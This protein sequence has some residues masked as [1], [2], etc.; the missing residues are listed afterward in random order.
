[1]KLLSF[2]HRWAG[3][4]IGLLLAVLGLSGTILVWEG[5][6]ISLPGAGD[7]VVEQ[8]RTIG[9]IAEREAA[10]GAI[11]ITFASEEIGLHHV[12]REGGAGS[13]VKQDG[14]TVATWSSQWDRPE[15]WIFDLHHHL[16]AGHNGE[17]AAGWAGV[18][19]LIFTITGA[20]LWWRSRRA[21]KW[22]LWP[23]RLQ[24]GPIVSHHRDIGILVAPLL[25]VSFVTGTGMLF[26][27]AAAAVLSPFGKID[28]GSK[29]PTVE[30][31]EKPAPVAAMLAQA[32]ARF[33]AAELRRLTLPAKP[34]QP[35]SV[36]MRQPFEWTPNGRTTLYFDGTGRLAKVDDPA[37]GS[38]AASINEK[39]YPLHSAKV[40]GLAWQLMMTLSGLGLTLLGALATWSFWFRRAKK[41]KRPGIASAGLEVAAA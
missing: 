7:P 19:G 13:Y 3:G 25:L 26:K 36:R 41:R 4:V 18:F 34:G 10:A 22:Q 35:W 38:R 24:P 27:D 33:P 17:L 40:G 2:L 21:F 15:L 30:P 14:T 9:Q 20:I 37:T 8:A 1:M 12:A 28:A 31:I 16:F 39:L 5:E 29:P 6:W 23:K 32:K 11:R